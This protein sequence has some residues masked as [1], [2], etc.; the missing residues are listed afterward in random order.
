ML[1][2]STNAISTS[3]DGSYVTTLLGT[4]VEG[5]HL[6][7]VQKGETIFCQGDGANS[8]YFVR[9]G[10]VKVSVLSYAGKEG[11]LAILGPHSLFGEESLA[12]QSLRTSTA[13]ALEPST[14]FQVE[15][16]SVVW[17]KT[18]QR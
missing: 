17:D 8:V 15:M 10:R 2:T 6:V 4:I 5:K 12:G 1:A 16:S 9:T 7:N 11:V 13:T 3:T 18:L 14:V